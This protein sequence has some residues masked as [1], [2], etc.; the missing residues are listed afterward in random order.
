MCFCVFPPQ[1]YKWQELSLSFAG[2]ERIWIKN[3]LQKHLG[4]Q[5]G[6]RFLAL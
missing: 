4:G 5:S 3:T 6:C 2:W 1:E